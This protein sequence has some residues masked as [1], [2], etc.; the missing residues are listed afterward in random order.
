MH[1]LWSPSICIFSCDS[2]QSFLWFR[3]GFTQVNNPINVLLLQRHSVP[4]TLSNTQVPGRKFLPTASLHN[5]FMTCNPFWEENYLSWR[6]MNSFWQYPC[7]V[8]INGS[9]VSLSALGKD[10]RPS[11]MIWKKWWLHYFLT[12]ASKCRKL[13]VISLGLTLVEFTLLK[14]W[15]KSM[16]GRWFIEEVIFTSCS[17]YLAPTST[18]AFPKYVRVLKFSLIFLFFF[19]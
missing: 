16:F 5:Q 4:F 8:Q 3:G 6:E 12:L 11:G 13:K 10:L 7:P 1:T 17:I 14:K 19:F 2:T 18:I 15:G 9:C